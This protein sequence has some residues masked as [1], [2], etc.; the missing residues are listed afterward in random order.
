M[1]QPLRAR[2][3]R[4]NPFDLFDT[5]TKFSGNQDFIRSAEIG[6]PVDVDVFVRQRSEP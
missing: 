5:F 6:A 1:I 2:S 3:L 4:A